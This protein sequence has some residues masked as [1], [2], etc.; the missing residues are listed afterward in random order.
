MKPW[1]KIDL[2]KKN[3]QIVVFAM[4]IRKE[5]LQRNKKQT[6]KLSLPFLNPTLEVHF[7]VLV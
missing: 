2:A 7:Y 4:S 5:Q 3:L 6:K 1:G